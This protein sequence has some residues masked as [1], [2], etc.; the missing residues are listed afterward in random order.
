MTV[1]PPSPE[2]VGPAKFHGDPDNM[3]ISRIVIHCT[4]GAEPSSPGAARSTVAYAKNTDRPSSFHY[5]GDAETELQYVYDSVVAYHAPPNQHS[6]G[7]ELCCSLSN[8]GKGHWEER[9]HRKMVKRAARTCARLALAYDVPMRWRNGSQLR[10][11]QQGFCGHSD[12][13][14]AWGQTT[15]WD[16]GPYFPK[17]AF[18]TLVRGYA[19]AIESPEKD[20]GLE[21]AIRHLEKK[22]LKTPQV[23]AAL[24]Y[25]RSLR[26]I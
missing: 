18:M 6:L 11:G 15:H 20:R 10:A 23:R 26:E 2:Y 3:P 24:R 16:P 8:S 14:D 4:A 13:R 9:G 1:R 19:E 22:K 7:Y 25:L 21:L 5:V 17:L 12:V